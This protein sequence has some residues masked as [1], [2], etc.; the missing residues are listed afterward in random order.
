MNEKRY[1]VYM[2]TTPN[3]KVYVGI[4]SQT[5]INRRWQGGMGYRMQ[6]MFYRAIV[7][8]GWDN[9]KHE[10]LY[11]GLSKE[12]AEKIEIALITM[13][14]S[15]NPS[16]GYN[17][18]NGGNCAGTH[19]EETKRKISEAQKGSKNHMYGKHSWAYGKK[20]TDEQRE[21]NRIGHLGQ[22]SYWKGKH[23]PE[24]AI[25]KMRKP[26]TEEH[27]KNLVRLNQSRL[28]VLKPGKCLPAERRLAKQK[29]FPVEA[30]RMPLK[31]K[32]KRLAVFIGN[33]QFNEVT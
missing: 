5:N 13:H 17:V 18:E 12:E 32:E 31:V 11:S 23:L 6:P 21:K 24:E 22:K 15:T 29:V 30:L 20:Q 16:H 8:Y 2:H 33:T 26:K 28:C 3:G 19:S 10:I 1:T 4:T 9:I 27:R 14:D 25:A 7:K